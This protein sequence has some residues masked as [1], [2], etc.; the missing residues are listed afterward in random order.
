[1]NA[2][3]SMRALPLFGLMIAV[4]WGPAWVVP[5]EALAGDGQEMVVATSLAFDEEGGQARATGQKA[6]DMLKEQLA[7]A[8]AE[9]V[10]MSECFE[11][12]EAK[13]EVLAGVAEVFPATK[14]VGL[15][16][17]GSFDRVTCT[18]F[19]AI[20]LLALGGEA[21]EVDSALVTELGTARMIFDTQEEEIKKLLH[22]AGKKLAAELPEKEDARLCLLL[23]DAHSPKI[24]YLV[25]GVQK[26]LGE[27]FP[28]TGGCA[29]KNPGQTFVYYE[30]KKYPDSAVAVLLSGDFEVAMAG[31]FANLEDRV[32]ASAKEAG[33]EVS[34]K[35]AGEPVLALGF[36]CAGRRSRLERY[37]DELE[38]LVPAMPTGIPLF[39]CYCAGEVG[40]VDVESEKTDALS[41]GSGWH[42]MLTILS[43]PESE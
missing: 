30:G 18:D 23:A 43:L 22:A 35:I 17:Y 3:K 38:A 10:L 12:P 31:R 40:P 5:S 15:A 19:D 34:E 11:T 26:E 9:L 2:M 6:A 37:E 32:I 28:I 16:T 33:E 8:E 36:N 24:R 1:M 27:D 20:S 41:G 42:L 25:E 13:A 21:V 39:G 14:I 4:L 7:G 29:N